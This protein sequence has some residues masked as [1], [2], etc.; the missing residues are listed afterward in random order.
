V[1]PREGIGVGL[2]E[3]EDGLELE[4]ALWEVGHPHRLDPVTLATIGEDDLG[5]LGLAATFSAHPK[6]HPG[7]DMWN[8]GVRFGRRCQVDLY[9]CP[10]NGP[11]TPP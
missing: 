8:F 3:V 10:A 1:L 5:V 7:G 2:A 11:V 6:K 9:R 4:V